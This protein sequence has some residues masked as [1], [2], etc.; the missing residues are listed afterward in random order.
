MNGEAGTWQLD[1]L[2]PESLRALQPDRALSLEGRVAIVT[3][4]GGGIGSW[5][6]A[7][8]AVA[9][10]DVLLTD[11]SATALEPVLALL[12]DAGARA[13]AVPVDL[14]AR[15]APERI[16]AACVRE[17]GGVDVLVNCAAINRRTPICDVTADAFDLI[18]GM[19]LRAPYFL[20]A[21]AAQRMV[22]Q[23]RGGAIVNV[24]SINVAVGLEDVSVYGAAKAA[25][26]QLTKVMTVEWSQ[27]GIRANCLSPGFMLTPL[28]QPV[29]DDE[30][31]RRWMLDRVPLRRPGLPRE[32]VGACVLL[33]SDAGSF[34]SGQTL[35]VDGGFLAGSR[36]SEDA[37]VERRDA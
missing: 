11:L 15:D 30:S 2:G 19:D 26:S 34:I 13:G 4:A 27:H 24:G 20:A 25:L 21:R 9:G 7:G 8:L 18:V 12:R 29:W 35:F 31:R 36:W 32:L 16:V 17:L 1:E 5:L 3:G 37:G 22:E 10:A 33:A 6:A 28:S 23:G 14:G